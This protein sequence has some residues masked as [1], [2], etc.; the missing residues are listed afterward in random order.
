M[1]LTRLLA[2]ALVTSTLAACASSTAIPLA[3]GD[4]TT[5]GFRY[6][7]PKPILIVSGGS[8]TVHYIPDCSRE[9][10]AK[11]TAFLTKNHTQLQFDTNGI[12]KQVDANLDATGPLTSFFTLLGEAAKAKVPLSSLLS[13]SAAEETGGVI[14]VFSF[15]FREDGEFDLVP[16]PLSSA[17]ML[18]LPKTAGGGGGSGGAPAPHVQPQTPDK[19]GKPDKKDKKTK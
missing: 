14:A 1:D 15:K 12:L 19:N 4:T 9:Y 16:I 3:R 8:A 18:K 2:I 6:C 13:E 5:E 17:H 10:A 7:A 11:L